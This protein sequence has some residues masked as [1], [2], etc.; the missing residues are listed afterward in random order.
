MKN[1]FEVEK[2]EEE[3]PH[4]IHIKCGENA[5][6]VLIETAEGFIVD[7]YRNTDDGLIDTMCIW[8]DNIFNVDDD[9]DIDPAGGHG[10]SSHI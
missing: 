9:D 5:R 3:T 2:T 1:Y 10:L 6:A 8:N 7:V 4:C